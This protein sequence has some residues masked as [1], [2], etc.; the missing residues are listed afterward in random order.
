[1]EPADQEGGAPRRRPTSPLRGPVPE[2]PTPAG[3]GIV[4]VEASWPAGV[5]GGDGSGQGGKPPHRPP[6]PAASPRQGSPA[7]KGQLLQ[8]L[9]AVAAEE[10]LQFASPAAAPISAGAGQL[11]P[12]Q[13]GMLLPAA[14][15]A[16]PPFPAQLAV[17]PLKGQALLTQ[18]SPP[19]ASP[20][21]SLEQLLQAQLAADRVQR[22]A[23]PEQAEAVAGE[24]MVEAGL[25][26]QQWEE[27]G[28]EDEEDEEEG[29]PRKASRR[30]RN[31]QAAARYRLRQKEQRGH[32][33]AQLVRGDKGLAKHVLAG[34]A[35]AGWV[36][37]RILLARSLR[38]L[39]PA[40]PL[41]APDQTCPVAWE[42]KHR[43]LSPC[44]P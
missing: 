28:E 20:K 29:G 42:A 36:A 2:A 43:P 1:M 9:L 37:G 31:R 18:A 6:A 15:A 17:V 3:P 19:A 27:E 5:G 4:P 39:L 26:W 7:N 21:L 14:V 10:Q 34:K 13:H 35:V 16:V 30:E 33:A 22:E 41:V 23:T 11:T 8:Q 40:L 38:C 25:Q 44:H 32:V 12:Q 24:E